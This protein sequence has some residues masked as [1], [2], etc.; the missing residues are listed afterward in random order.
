M[1]KKVDPGFGAVNVAK[2]VR[3]VDLIVDTAELLTGKFLAAEFVDV[4]IAVVPEKVPALVAVIA[5][6]GDLVALGLEMVIYSERASCL[7]QSI[8]RS[9]CGN[10]FAQCIDLGN[11]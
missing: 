11:F 2:Q 1:G 9:K 4:A 7:I 6:G 8:A 10:S 3:P 5:P